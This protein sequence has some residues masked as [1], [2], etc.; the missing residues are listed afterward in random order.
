M[1]SIKPR[2]WHIR[3]GEYLHS[4][5]FL[6]QVISTG[7]YLPMTLRSQR[8]WWK[9][10]RVMSRKT[11]RSWRRV[12]QG[13]PA[14][15]R[16]PP[17]WN[18]SRTPTQGCPNCPLCFCWRQKKLPFRRGQNQATRTHTCHTASNKCVSQSGTLFCM[19]RLFLI[20]YVWRFMTYKGIIMLIKYHIVKFVLCVIFFKW[21]RISMK[22]IQLCTVIVELC[23]SFPIKITCCNA[24]EGR[25]PRRKHL[26]DWITNVGLA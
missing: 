20:K 24:N 4:S 23:C 17:G 13:R 14:R 8:L 1:K 21:C 16:W 25:N 12:S 26:W 18:Y 5:E 3:F 10:Q 2:T 6:R 22:C 7:R 9:C 19:A 15:T 11:G